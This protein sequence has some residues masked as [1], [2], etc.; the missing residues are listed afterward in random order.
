MPLRRPASTGILSVSC[1]DI[2]EALNRENPVRKEP[3]YLFQDSAKR[4]PLFFLHI[5]KTAG[6]TLRTYLRN[7]YPASAVAPEAWEQLVDLTPEQ[8]KQIR[9]L[10]GHFPWCLRDFLP[11][12]VNVMTFMREPISRTISVLKHLSRDPT[13]HPLH[14]QCKG[15][16]LSD[17]LQMM[18][19]RNACANTQTALLSARSSLDE[20]MEFAKAFIASGSHMDYG[21]NE[22]GPD[23]ALAQARL[24][25]M[26][27][28]GLVEAFDIAVLMLADLFHLHPPTVAL[29]MNTAPIEQDTVISPEDMDIL[30]EINKLDIELY[31]SART[32]FN[33]RRSPIDPNMVI[34]RQV[35]AGQYRIDG[36]RVD[37][38]LS[39]PM[40]GSGWYECEWNDKRIPYRWSSGAATLEV[41]LKPQSLYRFEGRLY[42]RRD[43]S[44]LRIAVDGVEQTLRLSDEVIRSGGGTVSWVTRTGSGSFTRLTFTIPLL[45]SRYTGTDARSL[46]FILSGMSFEAVAD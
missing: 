42:G 33:E 9:L 36:P 10:Q 13:F 14:A 30:R 19:V 40:P 24:H 18:E 44:Q 21:S 41:P 37:L 29:S 3:T 31:N 43:L 39:D 6:V 27:F 7:Q 28:I 15:R 26:A 11:G 16:S 2:R 38:A 32:I 25:D 8:R 20:T 46:G 23:L 1:R 4:P 35:R 17:M 22:P 12:D 45:S 5:P 34:D